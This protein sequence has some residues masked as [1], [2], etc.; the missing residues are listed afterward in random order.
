[1]VFHKGIKKMEQFFKLVYNLC[2]KIQKGSTYNLH[3]LHLLSGKSCIIHLQLVYSMMFKMNK[4]VQTNINEA[5][6]H[7]FS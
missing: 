3:K 4:Q 1:M 2:C 5:F 7:N 6:T